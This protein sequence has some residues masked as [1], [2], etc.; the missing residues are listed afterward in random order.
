MI[1]KII[2]STLTIVAV[3]IEKRPKLL[4]KVRINMNKLGLKN[5]LDKTVQFLKNPDRREMTV[6]SSN[7]DREPIFEDLSPRARAIFTEITTS[8]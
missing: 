2:L 4:A 5:Q 8:N 6:L 1:R 3:Q 7:Y